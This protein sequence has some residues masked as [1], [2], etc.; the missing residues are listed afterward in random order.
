MSES[1]TIKAIRS[2]VLKG[3]PVACHAV[4]YNAKEHWFVAYEVT[5]QNGSTWATAGI[6]VLDPYNIDNT[7]YNGRRV[8][9]LTAM[10]DSYVPLGVSKIRVP[11]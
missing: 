7:S 5:G 1:D 9:I 4:G 10:Q 3:T 11:L 8:P 2:Y 6:N